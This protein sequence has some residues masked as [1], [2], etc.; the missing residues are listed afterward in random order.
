MQRLYPKKGYSDLH[1]GG[2]LQPTAWGTPDLV[3]W[4]SS[5]LCSDVPFWCVKWGQRRAGALAWF[6][7]YHV[8]DELSEFEWLVGLYWS[9]LSGLSLRL[10][11][12]VHLTGILPGFRA[13][14][15][16]QPP[17]PCFPP[18]PCLEQPPVCWFCHFFPCWVDPP[19]RSCSFIGLHH[20]LSGLQ[21]LLPSCIAVFLT[22]A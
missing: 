8:S 6:S 16:S 5:S 9:P 12:C 13:P 22:L 1:L 7:C 2:A 15:Q 3:L 21:L 19:S 10:G 20:V 11:S 4:S 14:A 17:V 18:A